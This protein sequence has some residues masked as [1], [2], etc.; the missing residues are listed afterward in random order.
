[1]R[2]RPDWP[3][4]PDQLARIRATDPDPAIRN[5][6]EAVTLADRAC[7]LTGRRNPVYLDAL[8]AAYA[9][10]GRFLDAART[11]REAAALAAS[12]GNTGL[13]ARAEA[14]RQ[15]YEAGRP[16]RRSP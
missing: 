14:A 6:P 5:G 1:M 10:A 11:A 12:Q 4:P 8:A 7:A 16:L 13:A 9:E 2:L 15:L 3:D